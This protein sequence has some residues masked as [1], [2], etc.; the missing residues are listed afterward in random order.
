MVL[1]L[2]NFREDMIFFKN[3]FKKLR[4]K[5]QEYMLLPTYLNVNAT[6]NIYVCFDFIAKP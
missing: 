6:T 3:S 5:G 1:I 4:K 2:V